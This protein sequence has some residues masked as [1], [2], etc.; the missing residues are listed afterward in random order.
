MDLMVSDSELE[1]E[2]IATFS[3]E[4]SMWTAEFDFDQLRDVRP[5]E[6]S[7]RGESDQESRTAEEVRRINTGTTPKE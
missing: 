6:D 7:M 1:V 4:E 5:P 3:V 2:A